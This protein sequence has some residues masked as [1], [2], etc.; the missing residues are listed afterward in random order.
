MA[1]I[2]LNT[3]T[4]NGAVTAVDPL[5]AT[6]VC[7]VRALVAPVVMAPVAAPVDLPLVVVLLEIAELE[8]LLS[9]LA[10][11]LPPKSG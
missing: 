11:M 1:K 3:A 4:V 10:A 9:E 2:P 5:V 8:L 7:A 6:A